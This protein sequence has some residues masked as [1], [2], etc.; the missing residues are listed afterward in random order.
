MTR[1]Q[2]IAKDIVKLLNYGTSQLDA[3][4]S[5]KLAT[6][7][8]QAVAVAAKQVQVAPVATAGVERFLMEH[9][10]VQRSWITVGLLLGV[11]LLVVAITQQN[12]QRGQLEEDSLLLSS[13]L[14]PEAYVDQGF[15]TWLE[16]SS[17]P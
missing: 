15:D 2:H 9:L 17:Q 11:L 16:Q 4:T 10:H 8:R 5:A 7:R 1:E 13:D 6:A 3:A 14:P 12:S